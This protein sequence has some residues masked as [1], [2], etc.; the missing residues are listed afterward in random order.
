MK[1][2]TKN[3][4]P[5]KNSQIQSSLEIIRINCIDNIPSSI[6]NI[7][8]LPSLNILALCRSDNSIE[9][10]TINSWIQLIKIPGS[11]KIN[12]RRIFLLQ[13]NKNLNNNNNVLSKI[14]LFSSGLNG[15]FIEWNFENLLPKFIYKN[16][17]GIWDIT[18]KKKICLFASDDGIVRGIKIKKNYE[19]YLIKQYEKSDSRILCITYENSNNNIFYTGHSN[20]NICKWNYDNG[21]ILLTLTNPT[22][23]KKENSIWSINSIDSQY[24]LC[25]DSLGKLLI[26]DIKFGILIKEFNEHKAPILSVISNKST[27]NPIAYFSGSDSLICSIKLDKKNNIWILTSSFR[28]QSH[29][30]NT[31]SMINNETLISGGVTTD[32]CIYHLNKNGNLYQKYNEKISTNIKRHISPFEHKCYYYI[33][34][35]NQFNMFFILHLKENYCDLWNINLNNGVNTFVAKLFKSKK[36]DYN[37]I[38]ANISKNGEIIG[39][40]YEDESVFFSYNYEKNEIKRLGKI[41]VQANFIFISKDNKAILLSQN[42]SKIYIVKILNREIEKE[43]SFNE[44]EILLSADYNYFKNNLCF[45]TMSKKLYYIKLNNKN[46][47]IDSLPH[48][49]NY[50]TKIKFVENNNKIIT[51]DE[52]NLI[53]IIDEQTE[54]FTKWTNQRIEK[55]DYPENYL[56]WYN[57][58]FGI[59]PIEK[60]KFLL[61]TDYNYIK[62]DLTKEIPKESFF[63]KNKMDKYVKSDWDKIIKEYH[64]KIYSRE[65]KGVEDGKK[66]EQKKEENN[67]NI[68]FQND[69]F[70]ITSRFNSIMFMQMMNDKI[71]VIENDWNKIIKSFSEGVIV[72]KYGH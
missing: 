56:K 21:S 11:Q 46:I 64:D 57:K 8:T 17:S 9:I 19:S 12:T 15:Y 5:R 1:K 39:I 54:K 69:N 67:K 30:I 47:Q 70:K 25:G 71:I 3:S 42:K 48:P 65:Y 20:G 14:R 55:N 10:W 34:D 66:E 6:E 26:Y 2:E 36:S 13:N 63:E 62:I 7:F 35:I 43:I 45:S 41:K 51:I 4:T 53:Y 23:N 49:D 32:I 16:Q 27:Q 29:D 24:L 22:I 59:C 52:N 58:I 28:G 68:N 61:Y 33:S 60:D 44:K 50:I 40:S 18:I 38:C 31:L 37:L 72:P